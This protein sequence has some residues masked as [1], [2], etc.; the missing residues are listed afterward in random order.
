MQ[1]QEIR[2]GKYQHYQTEKLYEIIGV[3]LHSETHEEM[4]IYKALYNCKKFGANRIWVRPKT[5]FLENVIHNGQ[6]VPRF[7]WVNK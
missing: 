5:M 6:S 1:A 7:K 4:V 3:A 2:H